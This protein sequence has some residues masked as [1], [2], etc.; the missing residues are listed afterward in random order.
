ME[1]EMKLSRTKQTTFNQILKRKSLL[2][3]LIDKK[4]A[5]NSRLKM[6]KKM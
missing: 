4:L 6:R 1:K 2:R 5:L 3:K